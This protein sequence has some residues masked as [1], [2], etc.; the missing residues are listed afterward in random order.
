MK[1]TRSGAVGPN[2]FGVRQPMPLGA[3]KVAGGLWEAWHERNRKVTIPHGLD[4]LESY[5]NLDN[6]RRLVGE[7]DAPWRGPLFADSD[8]Y[9][10]LEAIAWELGREDDRELREF[11]DDTVELIA[12]AQ[13]ESGYLDSAFMAN[14]GCEPWSNFEHGHELYVLGH[15]LQAALAAKRA[16]A[17]DRLLAVAVR[18]ADLVD[19]LF[20]AEDDVEYCGHPLIEM[21]LIELAREIGEERYTDLAERFIRRRGSGFIESARFGAP[22]YQDDASVLE[23]KIMRGHAVR[24]IYLNE[25]VTDLFLERG[26]PALLEAMRTQWD[27][28]VSCRL[29]LTGGTGSRH[30]DEA[31][32]TAYELP[33]DRSYSETCA[34][35]AL[36]GWSWRMYLATGEAHYLDIGETTLYNVVLSGISA[37]GDSFTYSNPLQRRP[38][39]IASREEEIAKRLP[40]F[41]CA[42]C[43]PNFMRTFGS[44]EQYAASM[45][46]DT[47]EIAHFAE[48]DIE[49]DDAV[50]EVRTAYP[51]DGRVE[52]RVNGDASRRR[53]AFRVPAW[54]AEGDVAIEMDGRVISVP[55]AGGWCRPD[56]DLI[57]G[58]VIVIE[59]PTA[60]RVRYPHRR[61]DAMR[62][63]LAVTRGPVVY[64]AEASHN[65]FD[66]DL[67][68]V[69]AV[70]VRTKSGGPILGLG[71]ALTID[72]RVADADSDAALYSS[73]PVAPSAGEVRQLELRP[74][75]A[76]GEQP[77]GAMRVWLPLPAFPT[78]PTLRS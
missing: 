53:I 60:P 37:E 73:E 13:D 17:D 54:A 42:C 3:A 78:H 76:W 21:A 40:W 61:A 19:D 50:I 70:D 14:P 28:M 30:Q 27:D 4:K 7:S 16:M 8:V 31:F 46:G 41:A 77:S 32:G 18:F 55:I 38:H 34:G 74:Y 26:D 69:Q 64:C 6:L 59:F 56:V 22:Y 25:G 1:E 57:D 36:F 24:A 75:A 23:T 66:I 12:R 43:P 11:F 5:G 15:M 2:V 49:L 35:I 29:Y 20:G 52:A 72:V 51:A 39:H 9:K 71:P 47:L 65:D 44:L 10:T 58:T 67:A 63:T 68:E 33:P 45:N 48:L 62:G